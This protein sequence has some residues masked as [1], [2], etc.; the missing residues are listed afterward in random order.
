ML[1]STWIANL[2]RNIL[3]GKAAIAE[4]QARGIVRAGHG[5][6]KDRG[7]V[8]VGHGNKKNAVSFFN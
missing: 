3:A 6:K 7:I 2:L 1:L 8:I 4:V 5:N